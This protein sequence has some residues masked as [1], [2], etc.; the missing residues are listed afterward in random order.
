MLKSQAKGLQSRKKLQKYIENT[1]SK[2][3]LLPNKNGALWLA[4]IL[5]NTDLKRDQLAKNSGLRQI[6][7]KYA[8]ANGLAY[9]LK[10]Q[11]APQEAEVS[12]ASILPNM[13]PASKLKEAQLETTRLNKK[14]A[15]LR[16]A[17]ANLRA[18]KLQSN[19]VTEL[20]A[21]GGRIT[22]VDT[23]ILKKYLS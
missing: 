13:V 22:P 4:E 12:A 16:A 11:I 15:D 9:S 19:A 18:E 1:N 17:N 5:R 7:E 23:E 10:G 6:L 20:I 14:I 21:K 3:E 8:N 2:G